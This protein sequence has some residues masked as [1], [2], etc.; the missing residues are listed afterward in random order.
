VKENLAEDR[1]PYVR[2]FD[3]LLQYLCTLA[4]ADGFNS[5]ILFNELKS[6]FSFQSLSEDEW[7]WILKF[8]TSGGESLQAYEEYQKVVV[9]EGMY[10][11]IDRK[12]ATRHRL[13]IGTIVSDNMMRIRFASGG[14]IGH[15]EEWFISRLNT[16]DIF[17]FAGRCLELLRI[18]D[19]DVFVKLSKSQKG[20]VPSWQGGRMPL[21]SQMS[22]MLRKKIN[23]C[24]LPGKKSP[25][26]EKVQGLIQ[27]QQELSSVP[28]KDQLLIERLHTDEGFHL[29]IF[30]FEGRLVHEGLAFLFAWRISKIRPFSFSIAFNDYGFEL[31]SDQEIPLLQA[32]ETGLFELKDLLSDIQAS[33]NSTEMAARKFRDIAS[34]SGLIFKGFPGKYVKD[35]HLQN[36]SHL[37]FEVFSNYD[38]SNLLLRQAYDEVLDFQLEFARLRKALK[39]IGEQ[40]LV[41]NDPVEPTPFLFPILVDRLREKMST[42]KLEDRIRRMIS[43]K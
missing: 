15:V 22:E 6:S 42:E 29:F 2:S 24:L 40:E 10:R 1:M 20:L 18:K 11:I 21:S 35:R 25:E 12:I 5:D 16:G 19:M 43:T 30:P 17:W 32:I 28:N 34:I 38:S 13:S 31:L 37:L 36:S 33:V 9:I 26:L 8:L 39:R 27:L 23:E 14:V 3:V 41:I 7:R 4:V